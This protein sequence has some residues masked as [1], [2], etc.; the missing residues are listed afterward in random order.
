[1]AEAFKSTPAPKA[2]RQLRPNKVEPHVVLVRPVEGQTFTGCKATALGR[3][4]K[5]RGVTSLLEIRIQGNGS[6][7]TTFGE[8][9]CA[10]I[11]L[12]MDTL[13]GRRCH[14]VTPHALSTDR[15]VVYGIPCDYSEEE[16]LVDLRENGYDVSGLRRFKVKEGAKYGPVVI[17]FP[18][19]TSPTEVRIVYMI[20]ATRP[21]VE[22]VRRC[23]KCQR[24]GHLGKHCRGKP[25]CGKCGASHPTE[26]C[27][28][29]TVKCANCGGGHMAGSGLCPKL[30]SAK[31]TLKAKGRI[32]VPPQ[33][34]APPKRVDT[35]AAEIREDPPIIKT[36]TVETP[37]VTGYTPVF[38]CASSFLGLMQDVAEIAAKSAASIEGYDR[39]RVSL[40]IIKAVENSVKNFNGFSILTSS[41][42]NF[43][44]RKV[45]TP[46]AT[47]PR[48]ETPAEPPCR[49][50]RKARRIISPRERSMSVPCTPKTSRRLVTE[51]EQTET[52]PTV[53]VSNSDPGSEVEDDSDSE[54]SS[55]ASGTSVSSDDS[56]TEEIPITDNRSD[57]PNES[58]FSTPPLRPPTPGRE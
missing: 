28:S 38:R 33:S 49:S 25:R 19:G 9:K 11:V 7:R 55:T 41:Q 40:K 29:V 5:S 31:N 46:E 44:K 24:I 4:L 21:Y 50:V 18:K 30:Q 14:T 53:S 27:K 54:N 34:N 22:K 26:A 16:L 48:P 8:G 23:D 1:M 2:F 43:T 47:E 20:R 42:N 17:S 13:L 35:R 37:K 52:R 12:G 57:N 45:T 56:V 36:A 32:A 39:Q 6:L 3:E 15:V 51:M 10:E 58:V